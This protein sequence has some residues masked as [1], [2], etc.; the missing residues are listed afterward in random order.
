MAGAQSGKGRDP[1]GKRAL[2]G[3]PPVA[4]TR[5]RGSPGE[6]PFMEAVPLGTR[7]LFSERSPASDVR[8][9]VGNPLA[10]RGSF[11]VECQ[12]CRQVSRVGVLDVLIFQFPIG[13]WLPRG[14]FGHRM[15]CPSC[16]KRSWCSVTL[17]R[18]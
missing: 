1:L 12:R 5:G 2:Y 10:T 6:Q 3:P 18:H 17:R 11:T 7:A 8:D 16:R 13:F 15:I 14:R 4:T 9:V